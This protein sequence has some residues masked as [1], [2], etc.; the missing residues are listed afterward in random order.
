[1]FLICNHVCIYLN[2][3]SRSLS[4]WS[5]A[6]K[7]YINKIHL[8]NLASIKSLCSNSFRRTCCQR[9]ST[10]NLRPKRNFFKVHEIQDNNFRSKTPSHKTKDNC[11]FHTGLRKDEKLWKWRKKMWKRLTGC[12]WAFEYSLPSEILSIL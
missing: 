12:N 5:S 11:C 10:I 3:I 1:M 7:G 6:K 4:Y 9:R 2:Y 8:P